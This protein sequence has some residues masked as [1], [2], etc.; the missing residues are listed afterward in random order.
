MDFFTKKDLFSVLENVDDDSRVA[1]LSNGLLF[2][3]LEYGI[4]FV[5][6]E[7]VLYIQSD[8]LDSE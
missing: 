4:K 8:D 6:G 1:I 5:D 7:E 3:D 2:F